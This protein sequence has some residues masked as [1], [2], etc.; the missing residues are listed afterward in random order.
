MKNMYKVWNMPVLG[1]IFIAMMIGFVM[2]GCTNPAGGDDKDPISSVTITG[3]D[4]F[5]GDDFDIYIYNASGNE[6][7]GNNDGDSVVDGSITFALYGD[8]DDFARAG[9][10]IIELYN[11]DSYE[12]FYYTNGQTFEQLGI[13]GE[14]DF[15]TYSLSGDAT[16]AFSQFQPV[17]EN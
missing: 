3:L 8:F 5:D 6:V 15:P 7:A 2:M 11:C 16:I 10:Y 14:E 1:I 13:D 17:P 9:S 4:E 12:T